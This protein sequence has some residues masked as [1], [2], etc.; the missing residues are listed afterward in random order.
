[1]EAEVEP[2]AQER[3]EIVAELGSCPADPEGVVRSARD[4]A[5]AA[6][7]D[8]V[9]VLDRVRV[10]V[11]GAEREEQSDP[12]RRVAGRLPEI[13]LE[14]VEDGPRGTILVQGPNG[15]EQVREEPLENLPE[16]GVGIAETRELFLK[17]EAVEVRRILDE[18]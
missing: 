6:E 14:I 18:R 4:H 1:I 2:P 11:R 8:V 13:L 9:R 5:V 16:H 10:A 17:Q 15:N 3:E 7:A 12:A